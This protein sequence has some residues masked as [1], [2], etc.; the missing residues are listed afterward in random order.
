MIQPEEQ[1]KPKPIEY[2]KIGDTIMLSLAIKVYQ[3]DIENQSSLDALD[4]A[5]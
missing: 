4:E 5:D 1:V 2:I 3:S